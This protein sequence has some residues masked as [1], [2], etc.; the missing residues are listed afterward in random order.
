MLATPPYLKRFYHAGTWYI[1]E[2]INCAPF[3]LKFS[4]NPDTKPAAELLG[5]FA[6]VAR[7]FS[8]NVSKISSQ[9]RSG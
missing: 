7:A 4:F 1:T 5:T 2:K 8:S 9:I 6:M 3:D